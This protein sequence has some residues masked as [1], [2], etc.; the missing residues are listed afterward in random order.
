MSATRAF[1]RDVVQRPERVTGHMLVRLYARVLVCSCAR[2]LV[3]SYART[4]LYSY[5]RTVRTLSSSVLAG[6][7]GCASGC[8]STK[9]EQAWKM[10]CTDS[11]YP[12]VC[13][14]QPTNRTY[15]L[16]PS[17][18]PCPANPSIT[19]PRKAPQSQPSLRNL[20]LRKMLRH[21]H[22]PRV[23]PPEP[24]EVVDLQQSPS[25]L[26]QVKLVGAVGAPELEPDSE[27]GVF[28]LAAVAGQDG[29]H[30]VVAA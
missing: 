5:A 29:D 28:P 27:N 11:Y 12:T 16:R 2:V 30:E 23:L 18:V 22:I 1:A 9:G 17:Q 19:R 6:D 24:L 4:F 14:Y 26:V 8:V 3:C 15:K 13:N 25:H 7:L 10:S 20:H 21:Y